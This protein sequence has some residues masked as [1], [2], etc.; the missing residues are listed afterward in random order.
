MNK[1]LLSLCA[2][3]VSLCLASCDDG[4]KGESIAPGDVPPAVVTAF[5]AK[6]PGAADAKWE[7]E[8]END[9]VEYEVEFMHDGKKKHAEY[10]E[11]GGVVE[12]D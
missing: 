12:E 3:T 10:E 9:K 11:N 2:L 5:S 4:H 7:K 8:N 6:Y 1:N